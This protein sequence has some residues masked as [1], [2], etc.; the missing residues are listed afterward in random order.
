MWIHPKNRSFLQNTFEKKFNSNDDSPWFALKS[1]SWCTANHRADFDNNIHTGKS[2]FVHL[3]NIEYE[4]WD[5]KMWIHPKNR[6]F[7]QNTVEKNFNSK[8]DSPWFALKSVLWC[9]ANHRADFENNIHTGNIRICSF[10]KHW[11]W[12]LRW[13][14]VNTSKK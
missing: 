2:E 4:D 6:S 10:D 13:K 11:I 1:V 5:E 8:D 12:S 3:T 14:N 7:L 9:T